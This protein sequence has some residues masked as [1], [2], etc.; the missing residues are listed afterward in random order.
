MFR[1]GTALALSALTVLAL[2]GC[3]P[4]DG[5]RLVQVAD[6]RDLYIECRGQGEPTVLFES[7]FGNNAVAWTDGGVFQAVSGFTRACVY[8]RP[9]TSYDDSFSR[10]TPVEGARTA[11][12]VVDDLEALIAGSGERGPFVLVAHSLGGIFTELY[13]SR[14]PDDVAG[15]VL[16]DTSNEHHVE[17]YGEVTPPEFRHVLYSQEDLAPA[18]LEIDPNFEHYRMDETFGQLRDALAVSPIRPMPIFVLSH[19]IAIKDQGGALPEGFPGDEW[20]EIAQRIQLENAA[21]A[22]GS[23]RV[24]ASKSGHYIQV[25]EPQLVI[26]A[27]REVVDAVRR[28]DASLE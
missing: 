17:Y 24:I 5:G 21:L 4:I 16:V 18:L 25:D 26:D 7:G 12:D 15:L 8:D 2:A 27:T 6:G 13:A 23:K 28:G 10:S 14:H 9:G 11:D 1:A 19:G 20:E 22:P 3:G